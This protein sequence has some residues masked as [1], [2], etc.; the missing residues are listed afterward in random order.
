[1]AQEDRIAIWDRFKE[2]S[3]AL[4]RKHNEYFEQEKQTQLNNLSL[5]LALCEQVESLSNPAPTTAKQWNDNATQFTEVQ[6]MWKTIGRAPG[7]DNSTVYLRFRAAGQAFFDARRA[8]FKAIQDEY[9]KN[10]Q[11]KEDL[12]L[13]V[14]TLVDKGDW[15]NT[16]LE[17]IDIQK[18][19]KQVGAVHPKAS[20]ALWSR[21]HDVCNTFF[22]RKQE[23]EKSFADN[24]KTKNELI[25]EVKGYVAAATF[26]ENMDAIGKFEQRW[27]QIGDMPVRM[28]R[29][30][31]VEFRSAITTL[32]KSFDA[33]DDRVK[34]YNFKQRLD[35]NT[36]VEDMREMRNKIVYQITG[37]EAQQRQW[38]N[39][40]GFFSQS[41]T[42]EK[43]LA[44]FRKK[45]EDN[46]HEIALL[47][48][49]LKE[50][51][52]KNPPP[53]PPKEQPADQKW[54]KKGGNVKW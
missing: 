13:R 50:L 36:S 24:L 22:E 11:L 27:Q 16:T 33:N 12:C 4:H 21:F 42:A 2:A 3:A 1:V 6:A 8:F 46:T 32:T 45:I 38:E 10:F 19:W 31:D 25:D 15:D 14:K 7:K 20:E 35:S 28:Q 23:Y 41:K 17:V 9:N 51:D 40:M 48:A 39:N 52:T 37:L 47:R 43:M 18:Q 26:E 53:P 29:R 49:K 5:K 34:L 54:R 44:D 30:M